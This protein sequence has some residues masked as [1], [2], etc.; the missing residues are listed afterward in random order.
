MAAARRRRWQQRRQHKC[1]ALHRNNAAKIAERASSGSGDETEPDFSTFTPAIETEKNNKIKSLGCQ[2]WLCPHSKK[3][4]LRHE[5]KNL[6]QRVVA[7]V[8][9]TAEGMVKAVAKA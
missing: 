2:W 6:K 3:V 4:S 1:K 7:V 8:M 9:A 5:H